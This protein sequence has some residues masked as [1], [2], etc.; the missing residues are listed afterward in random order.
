M[1]IVNIKLI[2]LIIAI[3]TCQYLCTGALKNEDTTPV[4]LWHGMGEFMS[5]VYFKM[6]Q[7]VG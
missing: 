5:A 4:V 2:F 6:G 1:N 7:N 3:N